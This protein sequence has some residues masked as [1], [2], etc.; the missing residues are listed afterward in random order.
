VDVVLEGKRLITHLFCAENAHEL[1]YLQLEGAAIGRF[2]CDG[3][4]KD[5]LADAGI[6]ACDKTRQR[7]F[8]QRDAAVRALEIIL[9]NFT[10]IDYGQ[11]N[12]IDDQSAPLLDEIGGES[13]MTM[14]ALM[15]K[16]LIGVESHDVNR[17]IEMVIEERVPQAQQG[18]HRIS[19][20]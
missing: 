9:T 4:H 17:R 6:I 16:A 19:R 11:D 5:R 12:R 1:S 20:R 7:W 15:E 13:R 2:P 3:R 18:I 8:A 14:F 10:A